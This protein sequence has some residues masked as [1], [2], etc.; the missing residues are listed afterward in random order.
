MGLLKWVFERANSSARLFIFLMKAVV[1]PALC[2][3]RATAASLAELIIKPFTK[4]STVI[5]SP[6]WRFMSEPG[7]AAALALTVTISSSWFSSIT[8]SAVINLVMLAM[9]MRTWGF[10]SKRILPV[11]RSMAMAPPDSMMG[12]ICLGSLIGPSPSSRMVRMFWLAVKTW[13]FWF[14]EMAI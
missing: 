8:K 1:D 5:F 9:G 4:L 6:L 14:R 11:L 13:G 10:F 12:E 3:A 7:V 2:S